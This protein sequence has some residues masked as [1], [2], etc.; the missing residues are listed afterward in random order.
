[1]LVF[2]SFLNLDVPVPPFCQFCGMVGFE[3]DV[4]TDGFKTRFGEL[5]YKNEFLDMKNIPNITRI[6]K[7]AQEIVFL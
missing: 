7:I 2:L 6:M 3:D 4:S 5:A 1:M